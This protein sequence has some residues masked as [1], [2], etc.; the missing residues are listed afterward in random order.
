[1]SSLTLRLDQPIWQLH[2]LSLY[3]QTTSSMLPECLDWR[4]ESPSCALDEKYCEYSIYSWHHRLW[5]F[6]NKH[7]EAKQ[8]VT[9]SIK[10]QSCHFWFHNSTK[11]AVSS[12]LTTGNLASN[13]IFSHCLMWWSFEL[14][15]LRKNVLGGVYYVDAW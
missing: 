6:I 2:K 1:M 15:V 8:T 9:N 13:S 4:G 7:P 10:T 3:M 14:L 11:P 12:L 5:C